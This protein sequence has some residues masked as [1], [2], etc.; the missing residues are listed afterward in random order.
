MKELLLKL[1][2]WWNRDL[3]KEREDA[4][5]NEATDLIDLEWR[6]RQLD[7]QRSG[8]LINY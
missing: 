1:K 2:E 8:K 4:Y 6:M 7:A 5:L 3:E